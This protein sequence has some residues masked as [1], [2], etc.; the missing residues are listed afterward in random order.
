VSRAFSRALI[1]H[2]CHEGWD[3]QSCGLAVW[4]QAKRSSVRSSLGAFAPGAPG[5]EEGAGVAIARRIRRDGGF[6]AGR[7]RY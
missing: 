6:S 5:R 3:S 2:Y 7:V 1:E 4:S